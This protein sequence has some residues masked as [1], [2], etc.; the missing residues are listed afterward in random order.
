[1][2]QPQLADI[3]KPVTMCLFHHKNV[4]KHEVSHKKP[5]F[6]EYAQNWIKALASKTGKAC[7][8]KSLKGLYGGRKG[9]KLIKNRQN[10]VKNGSSR[11]IYCLVSYK[12]NSIFIQINFVTCRRCVSE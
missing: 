3:L 12:I 8:F 10:T 9:T 11:R 6:C 4:S 2:H 7:V 5:H 1:M